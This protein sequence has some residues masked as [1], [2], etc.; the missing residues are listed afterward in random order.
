MPD[1]CYDVKTIGEV[2]KPSAQQMRV[3]LQEEV[4]VI[5]HV[6]ALQNAEIQF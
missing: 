2:Q 5:A 1:G 3:L 4:V 6:C